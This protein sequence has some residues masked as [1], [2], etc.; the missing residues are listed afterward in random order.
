[1]PENDTSKMHDDAKRSPELNVDSEVREITPWCSILNNVMYWVPADILKIMWRAWNEMPDT[2]VLGDFVQHGM[3]NASLEFPLFYF[4]FIQ[5]GY[6]KWEKLNVIWTKEQNERIKRILHISLLWPTDEQYRE[7]WIDEEEVLFFKKISKELCIKKLDGS[8]DAAQLDDIVNFIDLD[9]NWQVKF[10]NQIIQKKW[11]NQF[12]VENTDSNKKD[13]I[14]FTISKEQAS[15]IQLEL[16][17]EIKA[18]K[19]S[20]LSITALDSCRSWFDLSWWTTWILLCI[21]WNF[22]TV[23]W[24]SSMS[25]ALELLWIG[26][27]EVIWAIYSHVH[28]DHFSSVIKTLLMWSKARILATKLIYRM[29]IAKSADILWQSEQHLLD[30]SKFIELEVWKK[31]TWYWAT[32]ETWNLVHPIPTNWQRITVDWK[33]IVI[34]WDTMWGSQLEALV[35][36]GIIA[37]QMADTIND[38]HKGA[39]IAY[40]DGGWSW[41]HPEVKELESVLSA[42]EKQ[43]T[44]ITHTSEAEQHWLQSVVPLQTL[45]VV[46]ERQKEFESWDFLNFNNWTLLSK[47]SRLWKRVIRSHAVIQDCAQNE[48]IINQ[49]DAWNDFYI[50]I[51]W[52]LDLIQDGKFVSKLSNWDHFWAMSIINNQD[53]RYTIK[54]N[55]NAKI[56]RIPRDIF[57]SFV[58]FAEIDKWNIIDRLIKIDKLRPDFESMDFFKKIQIETHRLQILRASEKRNMKHDDVITNIN[59]IKII[60]VF[61]WWINIIY[62]NSNWEFIKKIQLNKWDTIEIPKPLNSSEIV[63]VESIGDSSIFTMSNADFNE[64]ASEIPMLLYSLHTK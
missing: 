14:D 17:W 52:S 33:S 40:L 50:V 3:I 1:M 47:W 63:S 30:I 53:Q 64:I 28:D 35:K 7:W 29:I 21:N 46:E 32:I 54:T 31:N 39:D 26:P 61:D 23:D 34:G 25:N 22:V 11:S 5:K 62:R 60:W 6:F 57:L 10:R 13:N 45:V 58:R 48:V 16:E 27:Q 19:R 56:V 2:F 9:E 37:Q 18:I 55:I 24:S 42:E 43:R 44:Y 8:W 15:N 36:K 59:D 4:L 51:W 41:I 49:W 20:A 38:S 12:E